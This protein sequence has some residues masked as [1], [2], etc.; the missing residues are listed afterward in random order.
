LCIG[1][2]HVAQL[3]DVDT[4]YH[5]LEQLLSDPAVLGKP[6]VYQKYA[7]EHSDLST[8]VEIY[9]EYETIARI[10]E[11]CGLPGERRR[12]KAPASEELPC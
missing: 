11:D 5:E 3:K 6:G 12:A 1:S 7:K 10:E 2:Y 8:L 4:R 9:R